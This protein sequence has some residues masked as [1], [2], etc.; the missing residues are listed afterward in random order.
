MANWKYRLLYFFIFCFLVWLAL[1]T[2]WYPHAFPVIIA[3]YG[4][5]TIWAGMFLFFLRTI[6]L[7]PSIHFLAIITYLLGV[8]DELQQLYRAPWILAVRKTYLGA[9]MLGNGFVWSDLV[10]YAIGVALAWAAI[11]FIEKRRVAAY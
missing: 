4:G 3:K 8:L 1:A 5:D 9:L 6:W 2:R 10:C 11:L 7:K